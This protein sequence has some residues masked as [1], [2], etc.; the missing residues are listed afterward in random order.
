MPHTARMLHD[1]ALS[2]L[3][4]CYMP[5]LR[6]SCLKASSTQPRCIPQG[7]HL[8]ASG[9][10]LT[11]VWPAVL[12]DMVTPNVCLRLALKPRLLV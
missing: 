9:S 5:T 11:P 3:V 2:S 10:C 8:K 4:F 6:L 1:A 7:C 12:R